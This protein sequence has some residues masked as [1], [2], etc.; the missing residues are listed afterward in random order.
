MRLPS[1]PQPPWLRHGLLL[2][3]LLA[4]GAL[5]VFSQK[6]PEIFTG[7]VVAVS[8]GDTLDVLVNNKAQRVRLWGVDSPEKKQDFGMKA[9]QFSSSLAYGKTVTVTVKTRDRY[10]RTVGIVTLPDGRVLNHELVRYGTA[11]WA[12]KYAPK[13]MELKRLEDEARRLKINIWSRPDA[14]A[15]WVFREK[16]K[17]AA[18]IRREEKATALRR[19]KNLN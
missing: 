19:S 5:S 15:P 9:K 11:W 17:V 14:V 7:R 3:L 18:R 16:Q 8:D 6:P 4:G 1:L 2:L 10:G 12:D 13:E